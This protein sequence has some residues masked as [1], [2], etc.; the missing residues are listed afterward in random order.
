MQFLRNLCCKLF[1]YCPVLY[2]RED[3]P[4]FQ[5][6]VSIERRVDNLW[7]PRELFDV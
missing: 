5:K 7:R 3:D 1:G 4:L 6:Y 2:N